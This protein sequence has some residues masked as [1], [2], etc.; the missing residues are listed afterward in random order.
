[1]TLGLAAELGELCPVQKRELAPED[2]AAVFD[3]IGGPGIADSWRMLARGGTL[4][5]WEPFA[6]TGTYRRRAAGSSAG[7]TPSRVG[8]VDGDAGGGT[9]ASM[10]SSSASS[11]MTSASR[12]QHHQQPNEALTPATDRET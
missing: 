10:R 7:L 3:H 11:R 12:A 5:S 2:V 4:V 8:R 9:I 6:V 1:M